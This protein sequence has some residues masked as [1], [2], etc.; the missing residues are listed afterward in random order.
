[1]QNQFRGKSESG[2]PVWLPENRL[3]VEEWGPGETLLLAPSAM[4]LGQKE[5]RCW[6]AG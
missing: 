1:M 5:T 2:R 3:N 6:L 4:L